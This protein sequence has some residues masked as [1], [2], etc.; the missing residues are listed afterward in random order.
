M[1]KTLLEKKLKVLHVRSTI[2]MYGAEQVVLNVLPVLNNSCEASLLTLESDQEE[3]STLRKLLANLG[4]TTYSYEPKGRIDVKVIKKIKAQVLTLGLDV[5]HTHDYKSLFYINNIANNLNIPIIHHI[6]G[7]LGNTLS[8]RIYGLVE[9][10]MMRK[11]SKILTVSLEQKFNL[12]SSYF[13]YPVIT[14]VNNG[15]AVHSLAN[16]KQDSESLHLI[17]VARFTEEKNHVFAVELIE[18]CKKNDIPVRLTLLGDGPLKGEIEKVIHSKKLEG[19]INLVGFTHNVQEWLDQSDILLI[20]SRTEGM[21]MNML[22]AMEREL[23]ILSTGVG[24]IPSLIEAGKC[25]HIY[26]NVDE[27]FSLIADKYADKQY[28]KMLGSS[29]RS[30]IKSNLSVDS[31]SEKLQSEYKEVLQ[32]YYA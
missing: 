17:M 11:V 12:E 24:E 5:I 2:G 6:H 15:T 31:Q 3:S 32:D 7:A 21:P 4:V 19:I 20:T 13:S 27:L 28:W 1:K 9:R 29:G 23:P 14:Q 30:Y 16:N 10:W 18:K 26:S 25:G 8:E 22:E